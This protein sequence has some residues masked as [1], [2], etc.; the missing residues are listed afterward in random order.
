MIDEETFELIGLTKNDSKIC[1]VLLSEGALRINE[2]EK[3]TGLHRRTINDC[4]SRLSNRGYILSFLKNNKKHWRLTDV[5]KIASEMKDKIKEMEKTIPQLL[6]SKTKEDEV[7]INMFTG[8]DAIKLMLEEE[9]KEKQ[10]THTIISVEFEK[11]F[12]EYVEK[13]LPRRMFFGYPT[14]LIYPERERKLAENA[15]KYKD[16]QVRF[17][18]DEYESEIGFEICG[19]LVYILFMHGEGYILKIKNKDFSKSMKRY[20]DMLWKISKS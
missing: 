20:F 11:K 15:K 19:D 10:T 13:T 16:I 8:K 3:K 17:V 7:E 2:L 18:P 4:L 9:L 5:R 12:W 6:K 1:L 14:Y